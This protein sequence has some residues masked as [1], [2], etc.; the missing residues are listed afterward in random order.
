MQLK[1]LQMFITIATEQS[2]SKASKLLYIAQPALS[3][4]MHLLEKELG[5]KLF[6]R[7]NKGILLTEAGDILYNQSTSLFKNIDD[8]K[9]NIKDITYQINSSL[10]IGTIISSAH[11]AATGL[12]NFKRQYKNA[13]LSLQT[14]TPNNLQKNLE[15]NNLDIIY[16]R[17]IVHYN[18]DIAYVKIAE[19]PLELIM[20]KKLDPLPNQKSIPLQKLKTLPLC[21]YKNNDL[22]SYNTIIFEE[23]NKENIIPNI[24][25]ECVDTKSIIHIIKKGSAA[26]FLPISILENEKVPY[27]ISKPIKGVH[28]TIATLIAWKKNSVKITAINNYL[29]ANNIKNTK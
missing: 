7:T 10:N 26:S 25:C 14:T 28:F 19:N 15:N 18:P 9:N 2:I 13:K 24:Y 20:H 12:E 27:L 29:K 3:R 4:Q 21:T 11:I 8:I 1:Q 6:T 5:T 23:L 22:W 17:E 16:L